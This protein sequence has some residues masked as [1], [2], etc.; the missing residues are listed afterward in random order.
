[1]KDHVDALGQDRDTQEKRLNA[2]L[3]AY[4]DRCDG[5]GDT[6][7]ATRVRMMTIPVIL[8]MYR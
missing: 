6:T 5:R 3:E 4:A 1:M 7:K 2:W 8:G